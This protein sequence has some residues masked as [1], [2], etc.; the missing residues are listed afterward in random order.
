MRRTVRQEGL[1]IHWL[2]KSKILINY[3]SSVGQCKIFNSGI[4]LTDVS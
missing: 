4:H 2:K 1:K 3:I